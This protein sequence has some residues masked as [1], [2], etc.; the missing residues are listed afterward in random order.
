MMLEE[1]KAMSSQGESEHLEFKATTGQRG[2]GAKAVCA[3][4]NGQ[5]GHVLF[6]VT[7]R[8][9]VRGQ[10]ITAHTQEEVDRE[11]RRIEPQVFPS[12]EAVPVAGERMV[13][14]LK[15]PANAHGPYTFD[16]RPYL[17]QGPQTLVMPRSRYE[18]LLL[19]RLHATHRWE[20]KPVPD[21]VG[22]QDLDH[23]EIQRALSSAVQRGR[24]EPPS[25]QGIPAIL[26]GFGLLRDGLLFQAAVALF[27]NAEQLQVLYPQFSLR[28]ARFRGLDRLAPFE[29]NRRYWGHAFRLL[30]RAESFLM[31]HTP[32]ASRVLPQMEREDLPAYLPAVTREG[33]ANALCHRDYTQASGCLSVAMYDDRL[34]I[35]NPGGLHFG[36]TSESLSTPHESRPWNPL[37]AGVFYRAGI[38]ESWGSGT[39]RMLEACQDQGRPLPSWRNEICGLRLVL[40][41]PQVT[42]Q[43]AAQVTP[44]VTP[45]V[46]PQVAIEVI[47]LLDQC[48][49]RRTRQELQNC[50][51]LKDVKHFREAYLHPALE[52][53]LLTMTIPGKPNSRLQQYH[54]TPK[55]AAILD[56]IP[57]PGPG[58]APPKESKS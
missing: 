52:A 6:G 37:I 7:D 18:E 16:G 9:E 22:I 57:K 46:A 8:G 33:L 56:T 29:D 53:G 1:L 2:E 51:G 12:I 25:E 23:E 41:A 14:V 38:I 36:L 47:A 21:G 55:G 24:M 35:V 43:V 54:L 3:M 31:D 28:L 39:T 4:L 45:Q 10:L 5:G 17:R 19:E 11:L 30:R 27:G 58:Q 26:R 48:R 49:D 50:L 40:T 13:L 15:V 20:N 34:E 42:P 44:Q 32:I